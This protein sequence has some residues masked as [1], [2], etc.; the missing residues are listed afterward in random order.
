LEYR[1]PHRDDRASLLALLAALDASPRALCCDDCGDWQI[2]GKSGQIYRDGT[3]YLIVVATEESARR[4]TNIKQ[5]LTLCRVTQNGDDE[6]ALHLDRLP[7]PHEAAIIREAT[8]VRNKRTISDEAKATLASRLS[9]SRYN[10]ASDE[11]GCDNSTARHQNS[12]TFAA[13]NDRRAKRMPI[14]VLANDR[15]GH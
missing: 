1:E 10:P 2:S 7:A 4:W 12:V 15:R 9:Q 6:G 14:A 11:R 3:G 5:R 13:R 8:R